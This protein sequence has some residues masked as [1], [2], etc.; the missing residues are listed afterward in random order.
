MKNIFSVEM[1]RP[2]S[3]CH[4][5]TM[6]CFNANYAHPEVSPI[7]RF[8][9][10]Q[11][12]LS[13]LC[14]PE[15]IEENPI[16]SGLTLLGSFSAIESF[17][18]EI[19]RKIISIDGTSQKFCENLTLTYGAAQVHDVKMMPE[20]ILERYSFV[21]EKNIKDAFKEMLGIKAGEYPNDVKLQFEKFGVICQ[22][23]HC[24]VHR[25]G[26]LGTQNA[27]TFGLEQHEEYIEKPLNLTYPEVQN[28]LQS[29]NNLVVTLN[30]FLFGLLVVRCMQSSDYW[31]WDFR[32]DKPKFQHFFNLFFSEVWPPT[33]AMSM[34]D[35]YDRFRNQFK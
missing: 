11:R 23:R 19:I 5:D 13:R 12:E 18:R 33:P 16:L 32:R 3:V 34:K 31:K 25:G 15:R 28:I 24:V 29:N 8:F 22:L 6:A 7:D 30:N 21:S 20:A 1:S 2:A 10:T 17:L 14:L 27:I 35:I 26:R 9:E 4:I